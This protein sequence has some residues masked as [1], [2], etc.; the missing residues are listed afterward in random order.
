MPIPR[1]VRYAA[2]QLFQLYLMR[3]IDRATICGLDCYIEAPFNSV[4]V[5]APNGDWWNV[6][7]PQSWRYL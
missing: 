4:T 1:T 6:P 2:K 3:A 7:V 5:D